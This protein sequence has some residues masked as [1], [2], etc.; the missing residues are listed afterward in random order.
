[1]SGT[2]ARTISAA[3]QELL[4][5]MV[6]EE[7]SDLFL[8]AGAPATVRRHGDYVVLGQ[9]PL[10]G[11][12][13]RTFALSAM[14]PEQA[15]AFE[16]LKE[17]DLALNVPGAGRFRVNV[18]LQ[19]GQTGMVVRYVSSQIPSLESLGL[20]PVVKQLAFLKRGLVLAVGAAG[21]GKTT[22]LASLLD[23]R[24]ARIPGHILTIEDPIEYVHTHRRSLV[25]QREVGLDTLSYDEA[26]RH[27]MREAPSVIMIGEIRDRETMQ[28]ALHYAESG[29]LCVSTLH[30][31][32]A[33]QSI[34]RILNFFPDT[35]HAQ[36]LLDLS[37]NLKAVVAQ[38]LIPGLQTRQVPAVELLLLTNFIADLL[39][40]GQV[41]EIRTALERS[42]QVGMC[43]F[44]Q[45]LFEL[46]ERGAIN[47]EDMLAYAD[48]RTDLSLRLRLAAG[49]PLEVSGMRVTDLEPSTPASPRPPVAPSRL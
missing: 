45:S 41:H 34:Q 38:R 42:S 49:T 18:N 3:L 8:I 10:A 48:N 2:D 28:H 36:I 32:N 14:T 43:T 19:R 40:K 7:A 4:V 30:A 47:Q 9:V 13:I 22:T 20:P 21:S 12:A 33:S 44:D 37:L 26:L 15:K 46:Y 25:T 31:N 5:A 6:R 16:A 27:A 24:N 11:E 29:H 39:Q 35:A 17:C 23:H 1:M